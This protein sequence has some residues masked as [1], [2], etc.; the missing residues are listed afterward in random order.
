[1][2]NVNKKI[3]SFKDIPSLS[4]SVR[5]SVLLVRH[6]YRES[7]QNG[8]LD[9]GLTAEGWDYAVECGKF[10][11]GMK[12]VC[13]GSSPRKRTIQTVQALV[14]GGELQTEEP[15][16]AEYPQLH[17]TAMFSPPE[18]L[19]ITI[20]DN[21]ISQRLHTYFSTGNEPSMV[22]LKDFAGGLADFLT[23]TDFGKK[24]VILAT[25]DIL[26]IALLSFFRVYPFREDDWCGYVQG[27][28]LYQDKNGQ[29]TICYAV[30]DRET[31][32]QYKLFV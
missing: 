12:D 14:K 6:S 1:M 13:F 29:W 19:G 9:P 7:L 3:I 22:A 4:E 17:D 15:L 8:N 5:K 26:L 32:Q 16:I 2:I 10:L 30:P 11:K 23:G 28:F 27:A 24:N 31:R 20:A 21:T 18:M 25:H